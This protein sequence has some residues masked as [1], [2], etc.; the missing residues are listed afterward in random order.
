M[1]SR[2]S[3]ED[4]LS[5]PYFLK[6]AG[7]SSFFAVGCPKYT[8]QQTPSSCYWTC[9]FCDV[10]RHLLWE[11]S[12]YSWKAS[13]SF[14]VVLPTRFLSSFLSFFFVGY[15]KWPRRNCAYA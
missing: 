13:S 3:L 4:I 12:C 6:R 11:C 1:K 10:L 7:F 8:K 5:S 15:F 2:T 9:E 14:L